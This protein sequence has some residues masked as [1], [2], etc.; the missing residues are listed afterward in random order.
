MLS[1]LV[2][3]TLCD[4]TDCSLPG[5]SV[6][7][8]LQARILEWAGTQ[9]YWSGLPCPSPGDLPNTG[10]PVS[11]A[12]QADTSPSNQW[13]RAWSAE[14]IDSTAGMVSS[15][16]A[17]HCPELCCPPEAHE[18]QTMPRL[19]GEISRAMLWVWEIILSV[20]EDCCLS[21]HF[22]KKSAV[23]S[24]PVVLNL[25]PSLIPWQTPLRCWTGSLRRMCLNPADTKASKPFLP[26][27]ARPSPPPQPQ[28]VSSAPSFLAMTLGRYADPDVNLDLASSVM[29]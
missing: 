29:T 20:Y 6:H 2:I 16:G 12:L 5:A 15:P 24:E 21:S 17:G 1:H 19:S 8:I 26:N 4:P 22:L 14:L 7:G 25:G 18:S 9:E 23:A 11:P 13:A 27:A 3:P 10:L 28:H